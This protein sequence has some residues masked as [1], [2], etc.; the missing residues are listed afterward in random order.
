MER[1]QNTG[2]VRRTAVQFV[3]FAIVGALQ[4]DRGL[5]RVSGAEPAGGLDVSGSG[6]R[7]QF[8][9]SS[10]A[11]P[12]TA[13]GRSGTCARA[14]SGR[15]ARFCWSISC[16]SAC[17]WGSSAVPQCVRH[18]RRMGGVLDPGVPLVVCQGRYRVQ[19]HRHA[20]SDRRQL[21][22][23]PAVCVSAKIQI[24][25]GRSAR[26]LRAWPATG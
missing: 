5:S 18:H 22:R 24:R 4:H 13:T 14:A 23:Q 26:C 16:P 21:H 8:A 25:R 15:W 17:R 6:D 11:M 10:T 19:A 7:L 1:S 2:E 12:G 9:A 20:G 3:K